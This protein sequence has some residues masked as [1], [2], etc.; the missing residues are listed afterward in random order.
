MAAN[1]LLGVCLHAIGGV[2]HGSFY[3][4]LRK[5]RHW[6]WETGWLVQGSAAWLVAPWLVAIWTGTQ[7]LTVLQHSPAGSLGLAY[8]F[9]MMWGFGSLTFG[10]TMRYLGMSLGMAVALGYCAAFGTLITPLVEG[11]FGVLLT[12]ASGWMLLGG[13]AVCLIGIGLCGYAGI[14]KEREMTVPQKSAAISEFSL[15]KGFLVA[16][17]SGIMSAGFAYGI[18]W[19]KPIAAVALDLGAPDI[20]KNA[21]VFIVV[22]AGGF[23]VN[24][25]W[26]LL[27]NWRNRSLGDYMMIKDANGSRPANG[28]AVMTANY[29]L[30]TVAGVIWYGGFFFYG[31]G[32][33][34]MGRYDFSSWSI[35]L[36]FVIMFSTLCGILALEWKGVSR[37]TMQWVFVAIL[38]LMLSTVITGFG[39]AWA[40]Q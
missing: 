8:L 30:A 5:L 38:I 7:P 13:V 1:A 28:G 6:R 20:F 9:G 23:T 21:P 26:C 37:R 40:K 15:A 11:K 27:L 25:V 17:F 4:P 14:R 24:C 16:T 29:L 31:M 32:T 12:T 22:M 33:T 2:A 39:N 34:K 10:L 3:V 19:G 36:A 35:H 18:N